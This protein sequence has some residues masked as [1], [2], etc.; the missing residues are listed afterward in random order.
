MIVLTVNMIR[1]KVV[2]LCGEHVDCSTELSL[3]H[4][5]FSQDGQVVSGNGCIIW[6]LLHFS[7]HQASRLT[8]AL[9][10]VVRYWSNC[11]TSSTDDVAETQEGYC[12]RVVVLLGL[13]CRSEWL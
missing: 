1:V 8:S 2:A 7:N 9:G 11:D 6:R 5:R 10:E 3:R 4:D 13:L 12:S